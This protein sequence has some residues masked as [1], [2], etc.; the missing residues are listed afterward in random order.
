M[1]HEVVSTSTK[2]IKIPDA[3]LG[4]GVKTMQLHE[5][6]RAERVRLVLDQ[7]QAAAG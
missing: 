7:T 2:R 4:V 5:V 1:T 3:C 6:L